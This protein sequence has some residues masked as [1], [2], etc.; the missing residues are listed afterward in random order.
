M[1]LGSYYGAASAERWPGEMEGIG[2][3]R[4]RE[5]SNASILLKWAAITCV[6]RMTIAPWY[7]KYFG[8]RLSRTQPTNL[9]IVTSSAICLALFLFTMLMARYRPVGA[10]T[11]A[12]LGLAAVSWVDFH[13]TPDLFEAGLLSKLLLFGMIVWSMMNAV[14]SRV[15]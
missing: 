6:L 1:R 9:Q 10:C 3:M 2:R 12:L 14:F 4:T 8:D 11:L 15:L 5:A 13:Q 7:V